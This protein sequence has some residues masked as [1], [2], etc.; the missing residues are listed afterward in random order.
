[1]IHILISG[2]SSGLGREFAKSFAKRGFNLLLVARNLEKLEELKEEIRKE[3][4]VDIDCLSV[5]LSKEEGPEKVYGYCKEKGLN[6]PVLVNNAGY[7]DFGEFT[8]GDI[9]VY[10]N[11]VDLNDRSLMSMTYLFARDMKK[12]RYGHIIN[13]ASIA[14]FMPGPYMAVY[15]ASKA[16][17]LNFSLSLKEELEPYSVSVTALCPGPV[18]TSFWD[19]AGVRMSGFKNSVLARDAKDVAQTLMKAFDS[20]KGLVV[21]GLINR[22]AVFGS[23]LLGRERLAKTVGKVQK[24]L[25]K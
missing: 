9:D 3:Y 24:K 8:E 21:D 20:R 7:G 23:G 14:G 1:M 13:V 10:K 6:V 18:R 11:M 4:P 5:D 15:Y 25:L 17:V 22:L 19:R 2:A 12:A 16:F